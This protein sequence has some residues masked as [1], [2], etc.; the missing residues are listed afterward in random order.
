MGSNV[1][2]SRITFCYAC[3]F[4]GVQSMQDLSSVETESKDKDIKTIE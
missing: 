2:I 3:Y 4:L 1:N